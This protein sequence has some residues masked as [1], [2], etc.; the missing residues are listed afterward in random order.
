MRS[1]LNYFHSWSIHIEEEVPSKKA[2][3]GF[4]PHG[5]I[6]YGMTFTSKCKE[7]PL[8]IDSGLASRVILSLPVS[9]MFLRWISV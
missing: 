8:Y 4:H 2:L 9:G 6:C 7:G 1:A 5:L 3:L